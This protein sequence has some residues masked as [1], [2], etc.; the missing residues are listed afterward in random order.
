M[1]TGQCITITEFASHSN[2]E[3]RK[4]LE[5]LSQRMARMKSTS[6]TSSV[7]GNLQALMLSAIKPFKGVPPKVSPGSLGTAHALYDLTHEMADTLEALCSQ[8]E[9]TVVEL[10]RELDRHKSRVA[11]LE[12]AVR[13]LQAARTN[14][15]LQQGDL[16]GHYEELAAKMSQ[17]LQVKE[18]CQ[19]TVAASQQTSV[20][21]QS[22]QNFA[23][24]TWKDLELWE[25]L[26]WALENRV[27]SWRIFI[28][29]LPKLFAW[30]V[31]GATPST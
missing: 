24:T 25:N 31:I 23:E 1:T 26:W 5:E 28:R 6:R 27:L 7:R 2:N 3:D 14:G 18:A 13:K 21:L 30:F 12:E 11:E 19:Q 10:K 22:I 20:L 8:K 4:L 16:Q 15:R 17:M 9:A 29:L